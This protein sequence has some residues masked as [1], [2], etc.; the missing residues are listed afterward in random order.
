[1]DYLKTLSEAKANKSVIPEG[2][3]SFS[4]E[5]VYLS[6]FAERE[7]TNYIMKIGINELAVFESTGV[8]PIYE[9]TELESLQEA[10]KKFHVGNWA[11]NKSFWEHVLKKFESKKAGAAKH[12]GSV[13]AKAI[14]SAKN[15]TFG[16]IH[17]FSKH[18]ANVFAANAI[19]LLKQAENTFN[20]LAK[21]GADTKEIKAA[22]NKFEA[23][24]CKSISGKDVANIAAMRK[25]LAADLVGAQVDVT[26]AIAKK[27]FSTMK[28]IVIGGKTI[29]DIKKCYNEEKKLY[30][31]ILKL[32]DKTSDANSSVVTALQS[33]VKSIAETAHACYAVE[34]DV[35]GRRF[36]EYRNV[37][38]K[39]ATAKKAV[40][41]SAVD[42][43]IESLFDF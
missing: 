1:M 37:L 22:K 35:Y 31:E 8:M 40:K 24:I 20:A 2:C 43:F 17:G 18:D 36:G 4:E 42:P 39:I 30:N 27:H 6:E 10:T 41:E 21:K 12:I 3:L 14:D 23:S 16:K 25:A 32:A 15:D 38:A 5:A 34:V 7:F 29:D 11:A 19:K 28:D 33:V 9:G 26:K 13:D